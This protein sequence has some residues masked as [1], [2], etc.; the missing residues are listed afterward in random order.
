[1]DNYRKFLIEKGYDLSLQ[2]D[3]FER[4]TIYRKFN[5]NEIIVSAGTFDSNIYF[6]ENG[7]V[8]YFTLENGK[9]CTHDIIIAPSAFGATFGVS[10]NEISGTYIKALSDSDIYILNSTDREFMN[11]K[12]PE[13]RKIG[14]RTFAEIMR[15]RIVHARKVTVMSP[16]ERY[17]DFME[18]QSKLVRNIPQ[19]VLA[20]YLGIT[21]ESLSRIR[22]R[23]YN[24]T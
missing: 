14:E 13:F 11:T 16:E 8:H 23:I 1:M 20:S 2:W 5:K 4:R 12:Y 21:P 10:P 24:K 17:I 9:E 22:K 19:Y 15:K 7:C 6:L 3:D 18:N